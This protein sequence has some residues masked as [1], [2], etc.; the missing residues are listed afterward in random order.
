MAH[1]YYIGDI[2]VAAH[3][4]ESNMKSIRNLSC[5]KCPQTHFD[6]GIPKIR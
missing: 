2:R 1:E 3:W 6:L 5:S 4:K